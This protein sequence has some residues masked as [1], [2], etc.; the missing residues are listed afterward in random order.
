MEGAESDA[1]PVK[2][3]GKPF[4]LDDL[5]NLVRGYLLPQTIHD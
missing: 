5:R 2:Y 4:D 3:I 1:G